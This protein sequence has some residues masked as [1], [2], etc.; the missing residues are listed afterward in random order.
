MN[1]E[2]EL[3][4][5]I[6][7]TDGTAFTIGAVLGS[8]ILVLPAIAAEMA[9]P[10]SIISWILMGIFSLPMVMT[11]SRMSSRYPNAG[12]IAAYADQAF[13]KTWGRIT[14]MLMLSAMT[15]LYFTV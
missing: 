1:N 15:A 3:K 6:T 13:G 8:G 9:G 7:W 2:T 11:I 5:S 14:G 4:K 10:A 12:G